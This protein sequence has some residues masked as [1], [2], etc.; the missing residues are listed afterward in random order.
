MDVYLKEQ[1]MPPNENRL[2]KFR[3]YL[4]IGDVEQLE[5][6]SMLKVLSSSP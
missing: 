4:Q 5:A 6:L 2:F 1:N 3:M